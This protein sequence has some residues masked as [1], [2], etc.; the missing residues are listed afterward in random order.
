[1]PRINDYYGTPELNAQEQPLDSSVSLTQPGEQGRALSNFANTVSNIGDAVYHREAQEE[2]SDLNAKFSEARAQWTDKINQQTREGNVDPQKLRD[3]YQQYTNKMSEGIKTSAGRDYF[4]RQAGR[5][6]GLILKNSSHAKAMVAGQKAITDYTQSLNISTANLDQNPENFKDELGFQMDGIESQVATGVID[7][8]TGEK[9]KV[10]ASKELAKGAI[11]GWAK[12]DPEKATEVLNR[13]EY[14]KYISGE[15]R[16]AMLGYINQQSLAKEMEFKKA[17]RNKDNAD[18]LRSE[19]WQQ[20]ALPALAK[21]G[22]QT[23]AILDSPMAP[24]EK[25]RWLKLQDEFIKDSAK[26]DPRVKNEIAR[27]LLLPDDDP[28]KKVHGV[29]DMA[30]YV[31]KGLN[32]ADV[33]QLQTFI[34]K[35]PEG[36]AQKESRH[37]L[38]DA[39]KHIIVKQDL[40][41]GLDITDETTE[42]NLSSFTESLL[43]KEAEF[44]Q[45]KK[46][47]MDLYNPSSKDYFL[48]NAQAFKKSPTQVMADKAK[49]MQRQTNIL[50]HGTPNPPPGTPPPPVPPGFVAIYKGGKRIGTIPVKNSTKFIQTNPGMS[51]KNE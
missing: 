44:R 49:A 35:T 45:E 47:P 23:Q 32:L 51:L 30:D 40:S 37:R 17:E 36:K 22:L 11:R 14:D 9:L 7:S 34:D 29:A 16:S 46:N 50:T 19:A 41:T 13:G 12:L 10:A 20:K 42:Y 27:Q 5:L 4:D 39:A 48:N 21:G 8:K 18:K 6:G 15:D 1:M 2:V 3:E 33:E 26:S 43:K 25:I 38:L 31:G 28:N 24:N